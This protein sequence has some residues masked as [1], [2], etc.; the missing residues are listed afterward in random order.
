M[1]S[2]HW[3]ALVALAVVALSL[4]V[5]LT[6]PARLGLDLRGGTRIVL[7]TR[8]SPTVVAD[9]AATQRTLEV[10]RQR[11]DAVGEEFVLAPLRAELSVYGQL[12]AAVH[13]LGR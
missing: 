5:A 7:E 9:A 13:R 10:L 4:F 2:R 6:T 1:S 3:R 8:N 12:S 11:V